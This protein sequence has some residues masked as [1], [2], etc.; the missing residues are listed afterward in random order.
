MPKDPI[1]VAEGRVRARWKHLFIV[2]DSGSKLKWVEVIKNKLEWTGPDLLPSVCCIPIPKPPLS[3]HSFLSHLSHLTLI[4]SDQI[5]YMPLLQQK[6]QFS[7]TSY[8]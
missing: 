7:K 6:V 2:K 8:R 4:L 1:T 3:G 5:K